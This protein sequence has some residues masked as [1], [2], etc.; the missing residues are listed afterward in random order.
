M[1]ETLQISEWQTPAS[2]YEEREIGAFRLKRTVYE[3]GYYKLYRVKGYTY[4]QVMKPIPIMSLQECRDGE[5]RDWM[6]DDPF[7]YLAMKEYCG[8]LKGRVLTAG[9]GLGL[10]V[11]E[12]AKNGEV[13]EVVVVERSPEVMTLVGGYMPSSVNLVLDDFWAYTEQANGWDSILLDIWVTKGKEQHDRVMEEEARPAREKLKERFP[14]ATL[15]LFGFA[16]LSDI[17]IQ[18]PYLRKVAV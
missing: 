10:A 18:V 9:L 17:D 12:L 14:S 8:S 16:P 4:F 2:A 5:W 11:Q 1:L 3:P 6:I 7:N 15:V 13:T